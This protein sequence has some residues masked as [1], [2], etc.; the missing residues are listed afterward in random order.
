MHLLFPCIE[1]D[2]ERCLLIVEVCRKWKILASDDTLWSYLFTQR[3]GVDHAT[4]FAPDG[5]KLWKD[6]YAVQDRGDRV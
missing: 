6:V 5:S 2:G 4:F 3:W 1:F